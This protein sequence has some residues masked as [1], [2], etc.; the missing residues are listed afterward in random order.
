MTKTKYSKWFRLVFFFTALT[1]V[2][3]TT[4]CASSIMSGYIGK[5][6]TS[7]IGD[8]GFPVGSYDIDNAKRAFVWQ[9]NSAVVIPGT[10]YASAS[11]IGNQMFASS[12]SS[13]AYVG[14]SRCSYTLIATQ[15]R[16]DIEGPAAWT[17][18]D[19]HKP[20]LM[21]E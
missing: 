21:C 12:Y 10:T 7:V 18:I 15:T 9:M 17:V 2:T 1:I 4:G 19:F 6:I 20:K 5:P 11:I 13:P 14:S 16:T 3:V 8:Y